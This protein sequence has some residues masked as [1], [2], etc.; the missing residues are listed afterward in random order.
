MGNHQPDQPVVA[1]GGS[2]HRFAR[3]A[4]MFRVMSAPVRLDI[5]SELAAGEL[6]V[7]ELLLRIPTTQS[8][9]S[10]HL[11]ALCRAGL[12]VR[13]RA[14]VHAYYRLVDPQM[15]RW[16]QALS[17][18]PPAPCVARLPERL[19]LGCSGCPS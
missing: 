12:L 9:L 3:V 18:T 14:G 4:E 6:T 10:Q 11:A 19:V 17:S 1:I 7:T 2:G 8:N 15:S 16:C 5:L 13:R